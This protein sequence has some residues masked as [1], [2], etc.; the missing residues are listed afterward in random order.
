MQE[1]AGR[2]YCKANPGWEVVEV[3]I[4]RGKSA[5]KETSHRPGLERLLGMLEA[6]AIDTLLV[7]RLDRL[8]RSTIHFAKI[9]QRIEQAG[10]E[11]VSVSEKFDTTSAIG[12]AMLQISI[13]F[14]E[15][16]SGIKAERTTDWHNHRNLERARPAGARMFGY[17]KE[18][19][20]LPLEAGVLRK[21]AQAILSGASTAGFEEEWEQQEIR[22]PRGSR[23]TRRAL[24]TTLLNPHVAALRDYGNGKLEAATWKAIIPPAD[25]EQLC[26]ILDDPSRRANPV[27]GATR[28]KYLLTGLLTCGRCGAKM[29]NLNHKTQGRRYRCNKSSGKGGNCGACSIDAEIADEVVLGA[30]LDRLGASDLEGITSGVNPEDAVRSIEREL[31]QLATMKAS[32]DIEFAE[33]EIMRRGMSERL[34]AAREFAARPRALAVDLARFEEEPL[35]AKRMLIQW[36]FEQLTVTAFVPGGDPALRIAPT[37]RREEEALA[38]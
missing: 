1:A 36:A 22:T 3:A 21:Y 9:W 14:A 27:E 10:G 2:A 32:G 4:D 7:Y 25:W 11:F 12:R 16:E 33:W 8:S 35:A 6:G 5:Y 18:K 26:E 19:K 23:L 24:R 15:L 20:I 13:V 38:A 31:E 30:L 29:F 28:A 37:P 34:E 17:S